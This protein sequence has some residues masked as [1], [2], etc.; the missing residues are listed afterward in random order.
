MST[1]PKSQTLG[2]DM[3]IVDNVSLKQRSE[4]VLQKLNKIDFKFKTKSRMWLV[5]WLFKTSFYTEGCST[6][7]SSFQPREYCKEGVNKAF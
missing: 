1:L 4:A 7:N 3:G 5:K 2:K 6:T